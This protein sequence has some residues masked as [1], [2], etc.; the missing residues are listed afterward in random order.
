MPTVAIVGASQDRSKY[1]NISVRAHLDKGWTV[2]PIHPRA[3]EIEGIPARASLEDVAEP[4]DRVALYLPPQVGMTVLADIAA[5]PG[6]PPLYL[7]PGTADKALRDEVRRLGIDAR[8][9][10]AIVAIGAS[11]STYMS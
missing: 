4:I 9:A 8:E 2:I 1:G 5:L 11:P 7:N 3:Q 6:S 10:C